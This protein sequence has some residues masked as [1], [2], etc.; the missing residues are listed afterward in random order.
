MRKAS[1]DLPIDAMRAKKPTRVPTVLTTEDT[2]NVLERLSGTPRLMAK[3]LSGGGLR[4]MAGLR[5]RIK[6]LDV[7][8]RQ[9]IVRDGNGM[10]DRVTML[11]E[12]LIIPLQEY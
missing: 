3:L 4:R 8:P 10:Q 1:L 6:D 7:A 12:S 2:L 5:L 11:P 9:I